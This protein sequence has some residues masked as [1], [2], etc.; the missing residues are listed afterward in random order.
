MKGQIVAAAASLAL[1]SYAALIWLDL[2]PPAGLRYEP[3]PLGQGLVAEHWWDE[4]QGLR[5]WAMNPRGWSWPF[6][7]AA[8]LAQW[9]PLVGIGLALA[10]VLWF[11]VREKLRTGIALGALVVLGYAEQ[12]A[13]LSLKPGGNANQLLFERVVSSSFTGYYTSATRINSVG[14]FFSGY[15]RSIASNDPAVRLCSHCLTHPP[16]PIVFYWALLQFVGGLPAGIQ[17]RL[18]AGL[19]AFLSLHAPPLSSA[20]TSVQM[21]AAVI[22]GHL[23]VA[24]T[25]LIVLPL[26][27]L[28]RLIAGRRPAIPLAALGLMVPGITLMSP[29]FDQFYAVAA[30]VLLY[31]TLRGLRSATHGVLWGLAAGIW[32]A[33]CLY[34]SFG[35]L[36]LGLSVAILALLAGIGRLWP[37]AGGPGPGWRHL[38][39]W[40]LGIA[41][42]A[43]VP[44]FLLWSA[45]EF[46]L[47][48][49]AEVIT[50]RQE[51][52]ITMRPYALWLVFN[53]VDFLQFLGLPL[54]AVCLFSLIP[55]R[56]P[57]VLGRDPR[58][59]AGRRQLLTSVNPYSLVFWLTLGV[60]DLTGAVRGEAGRLWLFLAPLALASIM[61]AVAEHRIGL[62][63]LSFLLASQFALVMLLGGRWLTP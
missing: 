6:M 46:D 17:E 28:A 7:P 25:A 51:Q 58:A 49:V 14:T 11:A 19:T 34:W 40:A 15:V 31:L 44:W 29:E 61:W 36:A 45:G 41:A 54:A 12:L 10:L 3:P 27:G 62:R 33:G 42:G 38:L 5:G 39:P 35:L 16:G 60:L 50:Y 55:I 32:F 24:G 8:P 47:P 30:C 63:G 43:L 18:R 56:R 48:Q 53:L 4:I 59:P 52:V 21:I 23:V 26:Y 57:H 1:V 22:G 2:P 20:L 37:A 13:T 9:L